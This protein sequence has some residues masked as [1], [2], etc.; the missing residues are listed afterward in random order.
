MV[1]I[2]VFRLAEEFEQ[3][4]STALEDPD[5]YMGNPVNAFLFVKHFTL[6]WDNDIDVIIKNNSRDGKFSV[7]NYIYNVYII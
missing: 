4:S 3:H 1:E 6:D 7:K 5:K 2:F